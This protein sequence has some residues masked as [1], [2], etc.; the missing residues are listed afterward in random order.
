MP[1]DGTGTYVAPEAAVISATPI[2]SAS[3]NASLAD[4]GA[5]LTQSLSRDG[6]TIP[7]AP[8]PMGALNHTN[9]GN[10]TARNQ[11]AALG[12]VQDSAVI[13][14]GTAGGTANAR[15]ITPTPS[16]PAYAAGQ[17]FRFTN[18][19]A[20]STATDPTLAV[21][22][23]TATAI[24]RPEGT[25]LPPGALP[26]NALI[27]VIYDGTNWR[28]ASLPDLRATVSRATTQSIA[29]ST[30][31]DI[32]FATE[33]LDP[34]QAWVV[35]TPTRLTVPA[36]V[37]RVS[38]R[39]SV[40]WDAGV[41]SSRFLQILLNG[42]TLVA[43]DNRTISGGASVSSQTCIGEVAVSP[44]DYFTAVVTQDTGGALF[45]TYAQ[46]TMEVIG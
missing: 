32:S 5:A 11:Y 40:R 17:V 16:I 9:V 31:T 26:A 35:G 21:S 4:I 14:G 42:T 44:G 3:Y 28:L 13:W 22:G 15:T 33:E 20:A 2:S 19:G 23:L 43:Q 45:V 29:T 10:A 25:A 39:A 12:Q 7:T 6:Q 41:V 1:R 24:K 36:G 30:P 46:M 27:T 38:L 37:S 18:G 8:L 34:I